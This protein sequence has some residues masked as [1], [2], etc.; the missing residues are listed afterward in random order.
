MEEERKRDG[1]CNCMSLKTSMFL[2]VS[3]G[4]EERDGGGVAAM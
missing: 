3:A 2:Y 4:E 1:K